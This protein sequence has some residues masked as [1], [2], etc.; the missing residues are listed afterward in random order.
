MVRDT[1]T[2]PCWLSEYRGE[3]YYLGIQTDVSAEFNPPWLGH[4]A[5]VE[6]VVSDA[7]KTCGGVVL[8]PVKVSPLPELDAS[9]NTVL[10]A[11]D[12]YDLGFAPPRPPG[13][14][15]GRLAFGPPPTAALTRLDAAARAP[16]TFALTYDFDALVGFRH[17]A[18]LIEV[19][20]YAKAIGA[21]RI[22]VRGYR[23]SVR[24]TDGSRL[25][26]RPGLGRDRARQAAE[27]L[28]GAG[29]TAPTYAVSWS[30]APEPEAGPADARRRRVIVRVSP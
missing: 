29:L 21:R 5:L 14:S 9:C 10:P 11:D 26:E 8:K 6:G 4:K 19:L 25:T 24:L 16:A 18:F 7:P 2:V 28:R 17:P 30:D 23:T 3:V 12:R 20:D 15:G 22:E 27:L 1:P 13:P